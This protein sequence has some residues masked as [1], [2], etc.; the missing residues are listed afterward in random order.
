MPTF[1]FLYNGREVDRM[2]GANIEM[3][4]AKIVQ[5]LKK[6]ITATSDER[7]FLEKFVKYSQRVNNSIFCSLAQY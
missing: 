5:Q 6:G 4:E 7:I 1:V 2:M 3:L